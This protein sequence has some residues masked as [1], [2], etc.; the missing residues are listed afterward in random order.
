LVAE[1]KKH[2]ESDPDLTHDTQ[3]PT[4]NFIKQETI[5]F[6]AFGVHIEGK[7]KSKIIIT[8]LHISHDIPNN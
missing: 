2:C 8:I 4:H 6:G 5:L 1:R 7:A 3:I